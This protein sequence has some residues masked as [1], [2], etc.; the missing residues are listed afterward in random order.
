MIAPHYF[1]MG[2]LVYIGVKEIREWIDMLINYEPPE[3]NA[4]EDSPNDKEG[5]E[6]PDYAKRMYS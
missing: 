2:L 5:E 6:L 4:D 1:W 3:E